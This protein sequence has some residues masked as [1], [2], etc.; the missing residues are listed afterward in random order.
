MRH[1]THETQGVKRPKGH[2]V[3]PEAGNGWEEKERCKQSRDNPGSPKHPQRISKGV[4]TSKYTKAACILATV[5]CWALWHPGNGGT[6]E[7]Q[8][9]CQRSV[10]YTSMQL[11]SVWT[12][13][14]NPPHQWTPQRTQASPTRWHFYSIVLSLVTAHDS[15]VTC[16]EPGFYQR[17]GLQIEQL[18]T[19]ASSLSINTPSCQLGKQQQALPKNNIV[20]CIKELN[21]ID[22]YISPQVHSFP[23]ADNHTKTHELLR[24][25]YP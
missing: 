17:H 14:W 20:L 7:G 8:R 6:P 12:S 21:Q 25:I 15:H 23:S 22:P 10:E 11:T 19:F 16:S 5:A 2:E 1:D 24:I 9:S 13:T 18:Y 4:R 3:T